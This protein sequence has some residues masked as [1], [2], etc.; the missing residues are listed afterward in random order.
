MQVCTDFGE[1]TTSVGQH[2]NL[3][4]R[5]TP[6]KNRPPKVTLNKL[7]YLSVIYIIMK[8]PSPFFTLCRLYFTIL[9]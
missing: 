3:K 8:S 5:N 9:L 6:A 1:F 7:F 2:A 4:Q